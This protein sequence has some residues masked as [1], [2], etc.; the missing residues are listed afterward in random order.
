MWV[1]CGAG[2]LGLECAGRKDEAVNNRETDRRGQLWVCGVQAIRL[3]VTWH[4]MDEHE[5]DDVVSW[6]RDDLDAEVAA[7]E[8]SVSGFAQSY[9]ALSMHP[10]T[11]E[12]PGENPDGARYGPGDCSDG[13]MGYWCAARSVAAVHAALADLGRPEARIWFTEFGFSSSRHWNGSSRA[14]GAGGESEVG[15]AIYLSQLLALIEGWPFVA[16][17]CWYELRD[18]APHDT[19]AGEAFETEREAHYGLF[20][21]DPGGEMKPVGHVFRAAARRQ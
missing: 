17:A 20:E 9:D 7:A 8:A 19:V 21:A 2:K 11:A 14:A 16:V 5:A 18:T 12:Y 1:S 13:A 15:Q 6:L 4:L 10:Y 3:P